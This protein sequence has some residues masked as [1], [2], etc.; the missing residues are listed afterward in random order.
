MPGAV[1]SHYRLLDP[2]GSGGMGV[3]YRAEDTTLGRTV[4]LKFLPASANLDAKS[5]KRLR[6]E[7]RTASALNHPNI[8]TIYEVG[9][10][11]DELYIAMEYVEGRPLAE[12]IRPGGLPIETVMRFA[13]QL[14]SALEHAHA[15]GVIHRDLK[16]LNIVITPQGDAKILDFGLARRANPAEFDRKTLET[17]T[18]QDNGVVG[19][20]HGAGVPGTIPYMAPE[21]LEGQDASPR[22]DLWSLGVVLYEMVSGMRPFR[23]GNLYRVCTSILRDPPPSLPAHVPPGLAAIIHRCLEKEPARRYQRAGE[24]RAALEAVSQ[25]GLAGAGPAPGLRNLR[26]TLALTGVGVLLAVTMFGVRAWKNR[27]VPAAS[28]PAQLQLAIL[29][30]ESSGS[31]AEGAFDNGL[32]ETL[33]ARLSS[34]SEGRPLLVIPASEIRAKKVLSLDEARSEFGVNMVLQLSVQRVAKQVRVNYSLVD[35]LSRRQ[36]SGNTITAADADPFGLQDRV[37]ESV[38]E[39]LA[40]QLRPQERQAL[41]EHGTMQ[42]AAYDFYLQGRGYLRD[43]GKLE[44]IESAAAVFQ[45][46][47]EKD[48]VFAAADAG[49]GETYWRK[50]EL[51]HDTR[52]AAEAINSCQRAASR[53]AGLA[54]AHTCLGLVYNGTGKYERAVAEYQTALRIEPTLDDA[55]SG[56]ALAYQRLNRPE[57]AEKAFQKA[58]ALQPNYWVGYN[59]LGH[60]HRAQGRLEEAAEM[61]TQVVALVPDSFIGYS[62]LGIVRSLQGR[63]A[64]AIPLYERSLAIRKTSQ[65]T[66]NLATAYFQAKRYADAARLYE[67]AVALGPEDA[68]LWGNLGDAYYWAPGLRERAPAAYRKAIALANKARKINPRDAGQLGTLAWYHAMVRE[69]PQA[70]SLIADALRLAPNSGEVHYCAAIVYTQFGETPRA[71]T[72]LEHAA[73]AGFPAANI[74]DTPNF[75]ALKNSPRFNVLL[76]GERQ[77]KGKR[78]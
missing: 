23:D 9:E 28:V 16:P 61:Y 27:G 48:P 10:S 38:V 25:E 19:H 74:R 65:A 46:A 70:E 44:N 45:R 13:R 59:R 6:E 64:E 41:Q 8:C 3:V 1:V 78:P 17:A 69:R 73:A 47:L 24:V 14:A 30:P 21:Q 49:L 67:E 11:P 2:L 29:P 75:E 43:M 36:L 71:L 26:R 4:A 76:S 68:V 37:A 20:S 77:K 51:T 15:R 34:L 40:L 5:R 53:D 18:T 50:F 57:D 32:V 56:L 42:P 58:I 63:Y 60:F 55:H 12:A 7:A 72:A 31:P 35:A 33:T 39:M 66:S 22:T 52:L 62:N 54:V